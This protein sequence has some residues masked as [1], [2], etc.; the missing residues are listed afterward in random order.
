MRNE[1]V[2]EFIPDLVGENGRKLDAALI[3]GGR[4]GRRGSAR[5]KT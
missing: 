1:I 3:S 5:G 4:T 2:E